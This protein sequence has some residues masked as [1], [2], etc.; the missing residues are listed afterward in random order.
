MGQLPV[1]RFLRTPEAGRYLG[2]SGRTLEKHRIYGT[3]Q[4]IGSWAAGSSTICRTSLSVPT[5]AFIDRPANPT[6]VLTPQLRVGK[7]R[8]PPGTE[9]LQDSK[10]DDESSLAPAL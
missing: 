8:L 2:L 4:S 6:W 7:A 10:G 9:R 3:G 5:A 1:K